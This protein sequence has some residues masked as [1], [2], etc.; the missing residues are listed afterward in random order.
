MFLYLQL[1]KFDFIKSLKDLIKMKFFLLI[2]C[3]YALE[4]LTAYDII[5]AG[6]NKNGNYE[7]VTIKLNKLSPND[8]K[9][10]DHIGI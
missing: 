8:I 6:L 7:E 4:T 10:E 1:F 9:Y 5:S 3:I 2:S